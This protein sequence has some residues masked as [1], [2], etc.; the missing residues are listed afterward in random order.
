VGLLP[1]LPILAALA[2][3]ALGG[4][5]VLLAQGH[6]VAANHLATASA[7]ASRYA[8]A[9]LQNLGASIQQTVSTNGS[10]PTFNA[11]TLPAMPATS[12]CAVTVT[13]CNTYATATFALAG[14]TALGGSV[15][16]VVAPNVQLDVNESRTAI[17]VTVN[18][19]DAKGNVLFTRP[20]LTKLRL[21]GSN[22][23]EVA[24]VEEGN[25]RASNISIGAAENEGCASDGTGCDPAAP[26]T[27]DPT[28]VDAVSVCQQNQ[29]SGSCTGAPPIVSTNRANDPYSNTQS[30]SSGGP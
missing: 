23:S 9:Y 27:P 3:I 26:Q 20:H 13:V 16:Q 30:V 1:L 11:A 10:S 17:T 24:E 21:F 22:S 18:V 12:L 15:D 19:V 2:T 6:T 28:N 5:Q 8:D 4:A 14:S 25:A 29:G 7:T